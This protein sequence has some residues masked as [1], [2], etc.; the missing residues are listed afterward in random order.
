MPWKTAWAIGED[1]ILPSTDGAVRVDWGLVADKFVKNKVTFRAE[2]RANLD[3]LRPSGLVK[4]TT[5][6]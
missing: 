3:A 6:P 5:V 4:I 1:C 2:T